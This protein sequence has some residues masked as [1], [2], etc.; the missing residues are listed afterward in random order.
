MRREEMRK[1][2]KKEQ[3]GWRIREK[4]RIRERENNKRERERARHR[5]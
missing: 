5:I 4:G 2:S 1:G 3:R